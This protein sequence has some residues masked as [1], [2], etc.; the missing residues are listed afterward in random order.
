MIE[1]GKLDRTVTFEREAEIVSASGAVSKSWSPIVTVRAEVR[2]ARSEEVA[3]GFGEGDHD[4]L[5]FVVRWHP[6]PI[7]TGD[8]VIY[9]GR[10]Y[11]IRRIVELGRRVGWK[12]EGV[13]Q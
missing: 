5:V 10:A 11:D 12:I 2:E 6:S 7:G 8:R 9:A 1:A 3:Q 13:A 4:T